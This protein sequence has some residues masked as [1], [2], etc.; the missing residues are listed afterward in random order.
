MFA[1]DRKIDKSNS[2][3]FKPFGLKTVTLAI[4]CMPFGLKKSN[5][6]GYSV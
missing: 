5:N 4:M 1:Q 3:S 6:F 2:Q